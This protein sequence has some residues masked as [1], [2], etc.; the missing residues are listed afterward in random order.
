MKKNNEAEFHSLIDDIE[1]SVITGSALPSPFSTTYSSHSG[2]AVKNVTIPSNIIT[3]TGYTTYTT[4]GSGLGIGSIFTVSPPSHIFK[5]ENNGKEVV[6]LN[7][8][9]S[10]EWADSIDVDV[11]A[12]EFAKALQLGA[13]QKAG[14][15][16]SVKLKMRDSV[17]NDIINIAKE[18][19]SLTA[20]D[21]TY[22]LE[23]SKIVEK[24]KGIE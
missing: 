17:F 12:K 13:E 11:A 2:S 10:V 16:N 18:K 4:V 5:L 14:I 15:T 23:A 1:K 8:D 21:L 24:L 20:D 7:L 22:L 9:G 3:G 19:G 6:R